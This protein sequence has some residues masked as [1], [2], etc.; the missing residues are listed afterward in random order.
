MNSAFLSNMSSTQLSLHNRLLT[1]GEFADF[2]VQKMTANVFR[3]K[4]Q[5]SK[6]SVYYLSTESGYQFVCGPVLQTGD[7]PFSC[8]TIDGSSFSMDFSAVTLPDTESGEIS[9]ELNI[10][11]PGSISNETLF[12]IGVTRLENIVIQRKIVFDLQRSSK[13]RRS[14]SRVAVGFIW[15]FSSVL[16]FELQNIFVVWFCWSFPLFKKRP[17]TFQTIIWSGISALI[18]GV[19]GFAGAIMITLIY[20]LS[21]LGFWIYYMCLQKRQGA[22]TIASSTILKFSPQDRNTM[23]ADTSTS[24]STMKHAKRPEKLAKTQ[25]HLLYIHISVFVVAFLL[26]IITFFAWRVPDYELWNRIPQNEIVEFIPQTISKAVA[27]MYV[28]D[29]Q[30]TKL[31]M[32]NA[33]WKTSTSY[34]GKKYRKRLNSDSE[35]KTEIY[36]AF[37]KKYDIDMSIFQKPSYTQYDTVNDWFIRQLRPGVRPTP[38]TDDPKVFVSP[39]DARVIAFHNTPV[40]AGIWIKGEDFTLQELVGLDSN[41]DLF[42]DG[43]M[44]IIRLAP[45]DYHRFHAPFNGTIT[46]QYDIS[47]TFHSVNADGMTSENYAIYNRRKVSIIS[48]AEFGEVAYVAVGATCVGSIVKFGGIGDPIIK[49]TEV[50]YFQFGG[51]TIVLVFKKGVVWFNNDIYYRSKNRVETLVQ[52]GMPIGQT[53]I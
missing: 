10:T 11:N 50:G 40:D 53:R 3:A 12:T 30:A 20:T 29:G 7:D 18:F 49:G 35:R 44:L 26:I 45:Q 13:H 48:T 36:D 6:P 5:K 21:A 17:I 43:S 9:V 38:F 46:H 2:E 51:S 24:E 42:K 4:D 28:F 41:P 8:V 22:R 1:T 32:N 25:K 34:C 31:Q 27:A 15:F 33:F 16:A 52:V 47:G 37:I 19:G 14:V 39:S 23:A